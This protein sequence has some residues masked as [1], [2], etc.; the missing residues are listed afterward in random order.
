MNMGH[1]EIRI[2]RCK[3]CQLC[4]A[5]CPSGL[6]VMSESFNSLGYLPARPAEDGERYP[7]PKGGWASALRRHQDQVGAHCSGCAICARMCP[8]AAITVY[9]QS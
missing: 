1:I 5:S 7:P 3:G 9:M 6:I 8:E 4:A 2:E